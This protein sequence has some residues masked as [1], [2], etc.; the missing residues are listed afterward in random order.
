MGIGVKN[1]SDLH[2]L[3]SKA[4]SNCVKHD[5]RSD[6][7]RLMLMNMNHLH[8]PMPKTGLTVKLLL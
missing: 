6:R 4:E 5:R 2:P 3:S 7:F 8:T 1:D